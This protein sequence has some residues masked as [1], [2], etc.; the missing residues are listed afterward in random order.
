M[1]V[2]LDRMLWECRQLL[3]L[4]EGEPVN[5]ATADCSKKKHANIN[6]LSL[7]I[8]IFR[9]ILSMSR[10]IFIFGRH[11]CFDVPGRNADHVGRGDRHSKK[12]WLHTLPRSK[13][14]Q[15]YENI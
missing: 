6:P 5:Q 3:S 2:R 12:L 1:F 8:Y 7:G 11:A 4:F 9:S 15:I 10:R 14:H 13:I